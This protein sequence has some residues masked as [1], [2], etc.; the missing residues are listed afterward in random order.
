MEKYR[1]IVLLLYYLPTIGN[2]MHNLLF[3]CNT[4]LES[5][6]GT[7]AGCTFSI[8]GCPPFYLL[9]QSMGMEQ[10][11]QLEQLEQFRRIFR[12]CHLE[13]QK[14]NK[15]SVVLSNNLF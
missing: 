14:S 2:V 7:Q 13:V 11:E 3:Y 1:F 6:Q 8:N 9:S 4:E 12:R 10:L 15:Y 5:D